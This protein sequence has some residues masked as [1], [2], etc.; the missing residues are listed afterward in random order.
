MFDRVLVANRGEIAVRI[1]RTLRALGIDGVAVYSDADTDARHVVD[2]DLAVRLGPAPAAQSYLN[3]EAL[4]A[5]AAHSG[6]QAIH[7]G[8]GF[9]AE[10]A[11]FAEAC[12]RAGLVFIGPTPDAIDAM[13]DKVRAKEVVAAAGVRVVPGSEGRGLDDAQLLSAA[14]RVGYPVLLKPAAGGGGK[15]MR[16]VHDGDVLMDAAG[17]ARREAHAAF[18]DDTLLLERYVEAPRHIEIQVVADHHDHVVHLGEREC[19]LQRRHQ[20]IVEECPSPLLDDATRTAMGA[21]AVDVA[22]ACGYTNAGTVEFIV[23]STRPTEFFFLEMN[24]R[25]Q[26]EHPVTE[27]VHGLDLVDLQLRIAAG[28]PL[29]FTQEEVSGQ[30]HAIEARIYAEDPA[31]DFLP[32]GGRVIHLREPVDRRGVRVD[33]SL[34]PG[35]S[36]GSDYDPMLAKVIAHGRDRTDALRRLDAALADTAVL[37]ATTNIGFLRTLLADPQVRAGHLDTGLVERGSLPGPTRHHPTSWRSGPHS[38]RSRRR[39]R[40][41][42]P[43]S[44]ARAG[45]REA[46]GSCGP[47]CAAR[48]IGPSRSPC[49][50]RTGPGSCRPT[51]APSTASRWCEAREPCACRSTERRR[52]WT[53]PKPRT[54]RPGSGTGDGPGRSASTGWPTPRQAP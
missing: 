16:L 26:V 10:N 50:T 31:R 20:K 45:A 8:Y 46:A 12:A 37:G 40:S 22:R 23:S 54:A 48:V 24:T 7:P 39:L 1:L 34:R 52:C 43:G 32:T 3:I 36:I 38:S 21:A 27:M 47:R 25:L 2:A 5:A 18:G 44:D 19:S 15:G 53:T 49:A 9:L 42:T 4:V 11:R 17:S 13:G 35:L 14:E 41:R 30:G 33:S 51:T 6:A 29:P 28:E